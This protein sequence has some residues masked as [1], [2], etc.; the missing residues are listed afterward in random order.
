MSIHSP[1]LYWEL[2]FDSW[3]ESSIHGRHCAAKSA[4]WELTR[5]TAT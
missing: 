2:N 3:A 5:V 4:G 1:N